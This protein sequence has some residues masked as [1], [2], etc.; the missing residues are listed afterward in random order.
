VAGRNVPDNIAKLFAIHLTKIA[1]KSEQ[2]EKENC[3]TN[4]VEKIGSDG[5][6]VFG[7]KLRLKRATAT[8]RPACKLNENSTTLQ[9]DV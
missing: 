3:F 6:F 2:D 1:L 9:T 7:E 4:K 8:A 5:A